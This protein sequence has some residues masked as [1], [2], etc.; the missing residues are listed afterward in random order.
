MSQ[1]L[2]DL[3]ADPGQIETAATAWSDVA[4]SV[5]TVADGARADMANPLETWEG[6]AAD[7][8]D[9]R[10]RALVRDLD[11]A[12]DIATALARTMQSVAG[13]VTA[14]QGRLDSS[15]GDVMSF[16][17]RVLSDG[18]LWF[19]T[20][21]EEDQAIV[22]SAITAAEGIRA[23]LDGSLVALEGEV[24]SATAR[25][26]AL[27]QTWWSFTLGGSFFDPGDELDLT[28][29]G[30]VEID[31]AIMLRGGE[32]DERITVTIDPE[33]GEQIVTVTKLSFSTVD[34]ERVMTEGESRTFRLPAG[35][36][37]VL[38]GGGGNDIITLPRDS[39]LRF[40]ALGGEGADI[41]TG[42]GGRDRLFGLGGEDVIK[43]GGGGDY[44]SGGAEADYLDGQGGDDR[45]F[46]GEGRDTLYGLGGDDHLSGGRDEDFLEGGAGNDVLSGGHG[47]D[48]LSGGRGRDEIS[49]G[50]GDDV[51]YG[52]LGE[53][54]TIGGTGRDT[55]HDDRRADGSTNEVNVNL[56]IPADTEHIT[57]TGSP[58]FIERV[59][60]DLDLLRSSPTG[61]QLL[62]NLSE[63]YDDSGSWFFGLGRKSLDIRELVPADEH[64]GQGD[65][66][67]EN[68]YANGSG[69]PHVIQY[70]PSI[71]DFR[72]AP[73]VVVLQH[74][75]GHAY[76][77]INGSYDPDW[78]YEGAD[79]QDHGIRVAE[80]QATGLPIDHDRDPSTPEIIDPRHPLATTE[81][82]LRD[83]MGLPTREHYR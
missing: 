2:W 44:V 63:K 54:R 34:G 30:I 3:R 82:G 11:E 68:S 25:W 17:R 50:A 7:A 60:A 9:E 72:G 66:W 76:D 75:M 65:P 29:I 12:A 41:I 5:S 15:W 37:L 59:R 69:N 38:H 28:G 58:E 32:G 46:G 55:S 79:A 48:V 67:Y 53:D 80:R 33:T 23:E 71:D 36:E 64:G 20:E 78:M 8:Y 62:A 39:R 56:Q 21:T 73:P 14:A 13:T 1:G 31:G 42:G 10:R 77:Y 24:A 40:T 70:L 74:E 19:V 6:E 35:K 43:A 16:E 45:I 4:R 47:A 18:S 81:N 22:R 27:T 51:S 52:G 49:G 57:I 26:D 61:Q 83:E